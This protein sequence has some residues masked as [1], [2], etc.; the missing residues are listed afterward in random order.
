MYALGMRS[1]S[2]CIICTTI[3][4]NFSKTI[5]FWSIR[6]TSMI[7]IFTEK[8]VR[9]ASEINLITLS[10]WFIILTSITSKYYIGN[11]WMFISNKQ[12]TINFPLLP[13]FTGLIDVTFR[14][15]AR[16]VYQSLNLPIPNDSI[17]LS[18][19]FIT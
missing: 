11:M 8:H 6:F 17:H 18:V 14:I 19:E 4:H 9:S 1:E 13:S 2:D 5:Q 7:R 16:M 10:P 15:R 3:Y 12:C